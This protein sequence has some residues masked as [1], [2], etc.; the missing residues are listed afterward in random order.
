MKEAGSVGVLAHQIGNKIEG[1]A[2]LEIECT[3]NPTRT[4][5]RYTGEWRVYVCA[6]E[7]YEVIRSPFVEGRFLRPRTF[8]SV[9]ALMSLCLEHGLKPFVLPLETGDVSVWEKTK[10]EQ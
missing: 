7:N 5:N 6:R 3:A 4:G 1:G 8:K 10:R 9:P 2:W